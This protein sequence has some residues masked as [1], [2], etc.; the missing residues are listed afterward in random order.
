MVQ[1]HTKD[2]I[3]D[4]SNTRLCKHWADKVQTCH[5]S[6]SRWCDWMLSQAHSW[7]GWYCCII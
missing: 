6:V 3:G 5:I 7:K 4:C 1:Q 2:Q